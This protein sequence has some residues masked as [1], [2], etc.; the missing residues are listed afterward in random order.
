M[1]PKRFWCPLSRG[2]CHYENCA[3]AKTR[4]VTEYKGNT[5][6]STETITHCTLYNRVVKTIPKE[7]E[8]P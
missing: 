4:D 8:K 7:P 5:I 2:E 3:V 1:S 6:I